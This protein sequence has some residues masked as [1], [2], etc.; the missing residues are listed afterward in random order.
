MA[1]SQQQPQQPP[2]QGQGFWNMAKGLIFR[3]MVIYFISSMFKK[4]PQAPT[5]SEGVV[6]PLPSSNL[7]ENGTIMV[8]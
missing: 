8:N 4:S 3:I 5:T 2:Q 1:D 6:R 7:F